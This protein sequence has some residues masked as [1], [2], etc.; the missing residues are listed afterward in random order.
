MPKRPR[1][2]L[3]PL[4]GEARDLYGAIENCQCEQCDQTRL[5]WWRAQHAR[6]SGPT[7]ARGVISSPAWKSRTT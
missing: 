1:K 4:E 7:P 2:P 5:A 6:A 3:E